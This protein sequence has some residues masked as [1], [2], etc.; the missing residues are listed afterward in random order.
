V[1]IIGDLVIFTV[2]H[3]NQSCP[4]CTNR[5]GEHSG[6]LMPHLNRK[7]VSEDVWAEF[8]SKLQTRSIRFQGGEPALH[9]GFHVIVNA[10]SD[11]IP[12]HI[13]T[14]LSNKSMETL[15][16]V[17]PGRNVYIQASFHGGQSN[18]EDFCRNANR[19][20]KEAGITHLGVHTVGDWNPM[21]RER[22]LSETGISGGSQGFSSNPN[23]KNVVAFNHPSCRPGVEPRTVTCP[24]AAWRCI[25][26]AGDIYACHALLYAGH[27]AGIIGNAFRE[28]LNDVD[29]MR[30]QFFGWCNPCELSRF[31]DP[32]QT[33]AHCRSHQS[34][35]P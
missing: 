19:L 4:Y 12:R 29:F 15:M 35:I 33:L 17:K 2:L 7:P 14:N 16:R 10:V 5:Y 6:T 30:C 27:T 24:M 20:I 3:C 11:D 26:P 22:L 21:E 34:P 1:N 28:E 13:G 18:I 32:E 23:L 9:P 25:D 31:T 8:L